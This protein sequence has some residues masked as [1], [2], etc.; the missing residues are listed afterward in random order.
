MNLRS[1]LV[2][3]ALFT[4][5]LSAVLFAQVKAYGFEGPVYV[6][7]G[8]AEA[9]ELVV[10]SPAPAEVTLIPPAMEEA[11]ARVDQPGSPIDDPGPNTDPSITAPQ[12]VDPNGAGIS[13]APQGTPG[14]YET[15]HEYLDEWDATGVQPQAPCFLIP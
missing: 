6:P 8:A 1:N 5:A 10:E 11:P 12:T 14:C 4:G 13:F 9:P 15:V 7:A 2:A 3:A